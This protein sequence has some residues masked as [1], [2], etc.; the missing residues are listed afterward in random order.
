MSQIGYLTFICRLLAGAGLIIFN[1]EIAIVFI[2][3]MLV[4]PLFNGFFDCASLWASRS[5][6]RGLLNHAEREDRQFGML[7]V[8]IA[9]H[10]IL[11]ILAA[12]LALAGLTA[13]LTFI[14]QG[15]SHVRGYGFDVLGEVTRAATN[16][17]T[18][19]LWL[20]V[21]LFSTLV[22][23]LA[24]LMALLFS[25]LS[26]LGPRHETRSDWATQLTAHAFDPQTTDGVRLVDKV[27]NWQ[28][29]GQGLIPCAVSAVFTA[30]LVVAIGW[31]LHGYDVAP[32]TAIAWV[33]EYG[34]SFADYLRT[35][36]G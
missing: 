22:P 20:T 1:A 34:V 23:T 9:G 25:G 12:A 28:N 27:A 33:A 21:L 32:A 15:I 16:W 19:G 7:A 8:L 2:A 26:L 4:L 17:Y 14:M 10:M 24:H 30:G 18:D 11:D 36:V 31:G 3:F 6:G 35:L 5:L 13:C 29:Y